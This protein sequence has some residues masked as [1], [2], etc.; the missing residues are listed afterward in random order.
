MLSELNLDIYSLDQVDFLRLSKDLLT[1]VEWICQGLIQ[2]PDREE[3]HSRG[4]GLV[5]PRYFKV[6]TEVRIR[7]Y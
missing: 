4:T 6:T 5:A 3:S 1:L 7:F 2:I